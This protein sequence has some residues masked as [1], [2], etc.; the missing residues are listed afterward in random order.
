MNNTVFHFDVPQNEPMEGYAPGSPARER[1]KAELVR[2]A[3]T[4]IEIPLVE[5][6]SPNV[7]RRSVTLAALVRAYLS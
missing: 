5:L 1:I 3:A 6:R 7:L 2:Q 4:E